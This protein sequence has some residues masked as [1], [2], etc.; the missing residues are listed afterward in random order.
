M[1]RAT[2]LLRAARAQGSFARLH[3]AAPPS[4]PVSANGVEADFHAAADA[5]LEALYETIEAR[6]HAGGVL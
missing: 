6:S 1:L 3:A 4:C 5:T 2:A